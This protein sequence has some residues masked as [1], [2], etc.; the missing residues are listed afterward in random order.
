M[1]SYITS[2][3]AGFDQASHGIALANMVCKQTTRLQARF[4]G[5][6]NIAR[7]PF[8]STL[9]YLHI[10][11]AMGITMAMVTLWQLGFVLYAMDKLSKDFEKGKPYMPILEDLL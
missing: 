10:S 1:G 3:P 8:A 5:A 2:L 9:A 7:S 11:G 4:V 6:W